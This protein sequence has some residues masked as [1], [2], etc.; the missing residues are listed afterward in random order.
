MNNAQH[1]WAVITNGDL[2]VQE[3]DDRN[4]A[5]RIAKK[6]NDWHAS[7]VAEGLIQ[8][9]GT[10][11]YGVRS[12][13][14]QRIFA[15]VVETAVQPVLLQAALRRNGVWLVDTNG[16]ATD[17]YHRGCFQHNLQSKAVH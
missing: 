11:R 16:N 15:G 7:Q 12:P 10:V 14:G 8:G 3:C 4:H 6:A 17:F 5:E 13:A 1:K 2:L 9:L